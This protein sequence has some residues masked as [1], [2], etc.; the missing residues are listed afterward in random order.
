MLSRTLHLVDLENLAGDPT[1]T[2]PLV[3]S[4][5]TRYEA[6]VHVAASDHIVIATAHHGAL[7]AWFG[8]P[9]A[10]RLT[11]S[12][13]DGADQRLL[14]VIQHE[15][16]ASRFRRVI[17]A[18]GDGIFALPAARL[19]ERGVD[20]CVVSRMRALSRALRFAVSDVL[21]IDHPTPILDVGIRAA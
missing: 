18:S 21:L 9:G 16:V 7:A 10:R 4:I 1:L 14:A 19:Q 15:E 6:T 17:I 5:R 12:G 2:L 20:D 13:P 3:E 11:G 8:W